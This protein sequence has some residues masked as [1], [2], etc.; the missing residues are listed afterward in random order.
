MEIK[1]KDGRE[2][3]RITPATT[4][5]KNNTRANLFQIKPGD[6]VVLYF[7]NIYTTEVSNIRIQDQEQ[8]IEGILKGRISLVNEKNKEILIKDPYIYKEGIGWRPHV[9]HM[10]KLKLNGGEIYNMGEPIAIRELKNFLNQ[11]AYIA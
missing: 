4:L 1:G 10:V 6:K 2:K 9:D 3:Y 7:D 8:Y 5:I 11:E